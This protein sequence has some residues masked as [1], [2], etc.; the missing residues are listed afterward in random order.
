MVLK[1]VKTIFKEKGIKPTRFRFKDDIRL[2]FKGM[3]VVEVT[4]FKEVK[5]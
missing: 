2:G 3:K 1:K 5:K 4:K